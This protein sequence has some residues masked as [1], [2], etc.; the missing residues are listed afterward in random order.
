MSDIL[1]GDYGDSESDSNSPGLYET[2][3]DGRPQ[4]ENGPEP[5]QSRYH[6]RIGKTAKPA[7][8]ICPKRRLLLGKLTTTLELVLSVY[9]Q[10]QQVMAKNDPG[11]QHFDKASE[12]CTAKMQSARDTYWNHVKSHRC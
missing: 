6:S 11:F 5:P 4:R 8:G 1:R 7:N 3:I 9:R 2:A 12:K 10:Q